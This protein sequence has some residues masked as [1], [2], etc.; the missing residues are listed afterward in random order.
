MIKP[1][2][3]Q[4]SGLRAQ[5][6]CPQPHSSGEGFTLVEVLIVTVL[7]TFVAGLLI[8]V[9]TGGFK[10]WKR[11]LDYGSRE[12]AL[13]VTFDGMRRDLQNGRRFSLEPFKGDYGQFAV[14]AVGYFTSDPGDPQE[15]GQFGYFLDEYKHVLCRS[16]IPYRLARR[17][18]L[19]D[20]CQV[21][22][23]DVQR[24]RFEYFGAAKETQEASWSESWESPDPPVAVKIS[25]TIQGERR[26]P[27]THTLLVYLDH[28][29][30]PKTAD[31]KS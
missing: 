10:V 9:L 28:R 1:P 31:E 16:F 29:L 24:V 12:Q 14:P 30:K 4:G 7:M 22:L 11:A 23:Q 6:N 19:R 20:R 5:G 2:S 17:M 15:I 8:A 18:R 13:L 26:Q 27:S 25:V 3:A 21:A